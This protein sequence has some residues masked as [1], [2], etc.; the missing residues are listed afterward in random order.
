MAT[1]RGACRLRISATITVEQQCTVGFM[2]QPTTPTIVVCISHRRRLVDRA[3]TD[4]SNA[5]AVTRE[6]RGKEKCPPAEVKS[7]ST[8]RLPDL[9]DRDAAVIL[10]SFSGRRCSEGNSSSSFDEEDE[11][12]QIR[13]GND[14]CSSREGHET[15]EYWSTAAAISNK[16]NHSYQPKHLQS[17]HVDTEERQLV[18]GKP[19][20][21][22][23]GVTSSSARRS[24]VRKND[25][26]VEP[27]A[28]I[29]N[30]QQRHSQSEMTDTE[31]SDATS[32]Y[33][34]DDTCQHASET[35]IKIVIVDQA[36][37]DRDRRRSPL[38]VRNRDCSNDARCHRGRKS[39]SQLED[40]YDKDRAY[41]EGDDGGK[42]P[43][44][45]ARGDFFA[46]WG[47]S[48]PSCL[49]NI[50]GFSWNNNLIRLLLSQFY[51]I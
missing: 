38:A 14:R 24:R 13:S 40:D 47:D 51:V 28:Q 34:S 33:G 2:R 27:V 22:I 11:S 16:R 23:A 44:I 46:P 45:S 6:N 35:R 5:V 4:G 49:A 43:P 36:S 50:T 21:A 30:G 8:S 3:I 15:A 25:N 48:K 17:T 32:N 12:T 9:S 39:K 29:Y 7:K 19:S 18:K 42:L 31:T 1:A 41:Y 26:F 20:S 10:A 37:G